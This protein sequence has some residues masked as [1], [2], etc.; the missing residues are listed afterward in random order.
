MV[1][2]VILGV[3]DP[4]RRNQGIYFV[5]WNTERAVLKAPTWRLRNQEGESLTPR[6]LLSA[7]DSVYALTRNHLWIIPS[8]DLSFPP[9]QSLPRNVSI[10]VRY[11]PQSSAS[12]KQNC[13]GLLELSPEVRDDIKNVID[14][15]KGSLCFVGGEVYLGLYGSD[16][17][18]KDISPGRLFVH[19]RTG[20]NAF[21]FRVLENCALTGPVLKTTDRLLVVSGRRLEDIL[22][23]T[24]MEMR[25]NVLSFATLGG[26]TVITDTQESFLVDYKGR[27]R[28]IVAGGLDDF[29]IKEVPERKEFAVGLPSEATSTAVFV[30]RGN[31]KERQDHYYVLFGVDDGK[32]LLYSLD[33]DE[34]GSPEV[35][36][37]KTMRFLSYKS[38]IYEAEKENHILNL[39]VDNK[40]YVHFTLRNLYFRFSIARILNFVQ[41]KQP[42]PYEQD[43]H[44]VEDLY[45][46]FSPLA[47][48]QVPHRIVTFDVFHFNELRREEKR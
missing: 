10:D 32:L 6:V 37:K 30:E 5:P 43:G 39:C 4:E 20:K 16:L 19:G 47:V 23:R 1:S 12:G 42:V 8:E 45:S 46:Y 15:T 35:Q 22:Q 44:Y 31:G 38:T 2:G 9:L 41:P 18:K 40:G 48:Y 11:S 7:N 34:T 27:S 29:L 14:N 24:Y 33:V 3:E 13:Q 36:Y 17:L 26:Y 25:G 28:T 21:D